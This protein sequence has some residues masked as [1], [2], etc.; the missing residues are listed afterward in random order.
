MH[1]M[2]IRPTKQELENFGKADFV[3]YNAGAFPANRLTAGMGSKTSVDLNLEDNEFVILGTEYAGEMKK[4]VFTV[5]NYFAPKRGVLSMHCSATANKET[6]RSSLLFG[7]SGTGKTTLSADPKRL[8]IGDDEH[9]WSDEGIFNIEGGCYAKAINLTPENE[10]DIFQAL[11]FGAVLENVVLDEDRLVD[12]SNISITENTR[13]AYPI[14]FIQNAKIPCVAGHPTD[15][16][17]LTCD[18]FGVLPPVSSLSPAQAM[19]HFISGYTAR[20]AGTEVGVTEPSATF[21]ACFGG[22]FLVWHPNKYAEL[23]AQKIEK[24]GT[25]A[26]LVNTGWSGGAYGTGKRMKLAHTR[27][28]VDAIHAG[29]LAKAETQSD[30]VFGLDVVI[31]CPNVP[32]EI[33]IPRNVWSDKAAYEATAKKLAG[34][35]AKNFATYES[36]V[37]AEVKAAGPVAQS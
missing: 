14:E 33:L 9:C 13:G 36:G 22:P 18:A 19:Y 2:L 37:S 34:L 35:F 3:I 6:G 7:L 28:I 8:L 4:G 16:I 30:P 31:Q 11:R 24:H 15:I 25:R 21:S 20:V 29:V 1:T 27:A 10:P 17:F 5:A 32:S 12:Y 23:L 26:W